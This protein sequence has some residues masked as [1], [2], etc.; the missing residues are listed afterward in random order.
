MTAKKQEIDKLKSE[1]IKCLH[2]KHWQKYKKNTT[3]ELY[4]SNNNNNTQILKKNNNR[5]IKLLVLW[6]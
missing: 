5:L 1:K 4:E 2:N 3:I 6:A